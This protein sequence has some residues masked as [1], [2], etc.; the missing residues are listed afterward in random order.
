MDGIGYFLGIESDCLQ[1]KR[2]FT[3]SAE[4]QDIMSTD[5]QITIPQLISVFIAGL[6]ITGFLVLNS[7]LGNSGIYEFDLANSRYLIAGAI[8]YFFI[9]SWAILAGRAVIYAKKWLDE[10]IESAT[11]RGI[12]PIWHLLI[13]INAFA[14]LTFLLC[15]SSVLFTQVLVENPVPK[16]ILYM[17][18]LFL[19]SYTWSRFNLNVR[20]PRAQLLFV[21]TTNIVGTIVFFTTVNILSVTMFVFFHFILISW[22]INLIC[23]SYEDRVITTGKL[24]Y[25]LFF[26]VI[27]ILLNSALFGKFYYEHIKLSFGGGQPQAVEI[28]ASDMSV[29]LG[30]KEMG[31]DLK[32]PF[33][34]ILIH[35][36]KDEYFIDIE[37]QTIQL[38][39]SAITG[40]KILPAKDTKYP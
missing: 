2:L 29:V 33:K 40:F 15:L 19:V 38:D 14:R 4:N 35:K 25:D 27:F 30:L 23:E 3:L 32:R 12:S 1:D 16:L 22:Y 11:K 39:R 26:V 21:L 7:H 8:F 9:A 5:T 6:Y 34:A 24:I 28:M 17:M 31:I 13:V 37:G 20:F 18:L 10:D 36:N